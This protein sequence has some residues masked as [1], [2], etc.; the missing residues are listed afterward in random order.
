MGSTILFFDDWHL[1]QRV[2]VDRHIGQP[3]T[4]GKFVDPYGDIAFAY[5]TVFKDQESGR[6]RCLYQNFLYDKFIHPDDVVTRGGGELLNRSVPVVIESDDALNWRI[7]DL[8]DTVPLRDR[9][10][11]HQILPLDK[12]REWGPAFYDERAEDPSERIKGFVS[13][14]KDQLDPIAPLWVSPDGIHWKHQEGAAWHPIGIDPA[15]TA[16]WNPLRQS[17]VIAARPAWGDRRMA[18]YE[19]TDWVNYSKPEL[20]LQADALDTPMAEIYGMPVFPYEDNFVG[21]TW[22]FH[23]DQD[24]VSRPGKGYLGTNDCQLAYSFNGSHF[25][26]GL[27]DPFV[28]NAEPGEDGGAVI[29]PT[30]LVRD[31]D[32][33]RICSSGGRLEHGE[34]LGSP[35]NPQSALLFQELRLDGFVYLQSAGGWGNITTRIM[36]ANGPE[37]NMNVLA[38]HGIVQAQV[39]DDTGEPIEG[40]S[41]EDCIPFT[42]DN[43]R[44]S[45]EWR[46]GRRFGGIGK[47][48][49]RLGVRMLNA[50]LYAIR[51]NF[52]PIASMDRALFEEKGTEPPPIST[53]W[54]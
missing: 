13:F 20:A 2:S 52:H 12:F 29:Y 50:R 8:T 30:S 48:I 14:G 47:R 11:P 51:G 34:G 40:Y 31:G 27:R 3:R 37:L 36:F 35:E 24:L 41:F 22:M 25:Q 4:A 53:Y 45:P 49:V 54:S 33:L 9:R 39:M 38:P 46:D 15:I 7:P 16:H 1:A 26:R 23:P 43:V 32:M 42:G 19:T 6:W 28:P 5:P 17:Y 44:W 18:V 21:F 10:T